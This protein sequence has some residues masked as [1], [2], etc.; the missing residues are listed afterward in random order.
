MFVKTETGGTARKKAVKIMLIILAIIVVLAGGV[1][2]ML[3]Q[4]AKSIG[5]GSGPADYETR[6]NI[7]N[8]VAGNSS[9][10]KL[11]DMNIDS[12]QSNVTFASMGFAKAIVNSNYSDEES[13]I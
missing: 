3:Y 12:S 6:V 11:D 10:S 9:R 13:S 1:I 2:F 8:K 4:G 5:V 7:W